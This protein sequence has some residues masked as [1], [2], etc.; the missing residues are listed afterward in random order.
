M[1]KTLLVL[2]TIVTVGI[3]AQADVHVDLLAGDLKANDTG[4]AVDPVGSLLLLISTPSS[5]SNTTTATALQAGGSFVTGSDKIEFALS[6][7][8]NAGGGT[9]DVD[10]FNFSPSASGL[11]LGLRWF[12]GITYSAYQTAVA[13]GTAA[14]SQLLTAGLYYGTFQGDP[15]VA[16]NGGNDPWITLPAS[17]GASITINLF[18]ASLNTSLGA[19]L[20]DAYANS[21]GYASVK[22]VPEPTVLVLTGAGLL[23][24]ASRR[25]RS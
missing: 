5:F 19:G 23:M 11:T 2:S 24:L 13:S 4:S 15:S 1:K 14:V 6:M 8:N 9:A 22:V 18:T 20:G 12:P 25:R 3:S 16:R 7:N 10:S 17:S 21:V